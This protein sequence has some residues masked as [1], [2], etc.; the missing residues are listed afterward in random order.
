M[1]LKT[2][3]H[4]AIFLA[5]SNAIRLRRVGLHYMADHIG[6]RI[7][8]RLAGKRKVKTVKS[9]VSKKKVTERK[10]ENILLQALY[11]RLLNK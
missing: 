11:I 7:V 2:L 4:G 3:S 10:C 8:L 6:P 1:I 9:E 5:T